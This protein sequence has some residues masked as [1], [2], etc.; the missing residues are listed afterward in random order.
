L[1]VE[2]FD[3]V[4]EHS[5]GRRIWR[6]RETRHAIEDGDLSAEELLNDRE[7]FL[8]LFEPSASLLLRVEEDREML[9]GALRVHLLVQEGDCQR[10]LQRAVFAVAIIVDLHTDNTVR[11]NAASTLHV[12]HDEGEELGKGLLA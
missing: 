3:K 10:R 1:E 6:H 2:R 11:E 12:A 9:L 7:S 4:R 5:S 8:V